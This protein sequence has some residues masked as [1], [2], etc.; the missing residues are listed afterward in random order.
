MINLPPFQIISQIW[1]SRKLI[2][3]HIKGW[4]VYRIHR[5]WWYRFSTYVERNRVAVMFK[6]IT[7]V[8]VSVLLY[9]WQICCFG[10][11]LLSSSFSSLKHFKRTMSSTTVS[12][13][14]AIL[15]NFENCISLFRLI[16]LIEESAGSGNS[17]V[18]WKWL[19]H[20]KE[21]NKTFTFLFE[22]EW[23]VERRTTFLHQIVIQIYSTNNLIFT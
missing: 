5:I 7:R 4:C 15:W 13:E 23:T 14:F 22:S 3:L 9:I 20:R 17:E 12:D 16:I 18:T 10:M 1:Y 19:F 2:L 21:G 8:I 6:S 11:N